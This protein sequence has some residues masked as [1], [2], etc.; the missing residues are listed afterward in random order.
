MKNYSDPRM[1]TVEHI[2]NQTM[3]Q[4]FGCNRC[5]SSHIERKLSKCD[6][7]FERELEESEIRELER[8]VNEVID[9]DLPIKEEFVTKEEAKELCSLKRLSDEAGDDIRIIR[10]GDYD[11][12]PCIGTHVKTTKEIGKFRITTTTLKEG[13]LRIRFKVAG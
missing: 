6:Y 5:F 2:L 10:V 12:C 4:L 8:R 1:H 7:H 9:R 11:T 3:V 13:V